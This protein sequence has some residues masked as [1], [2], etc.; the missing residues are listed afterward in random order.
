M[1]ILIKYFLTFL[2]KIYPNLFFLIFG[3]NYKKNKI[4][5]SFTKN[6]LTY[7]GIAYVDINEILFEKKFN[8]EEV[9]FKNYRIEESPHFNLI[10][11]Y[12]IYNKSH[13]NKLEH[14][15]YFKLFYHRKIILFKNNIHND[16]NFNKYFNRKYNN[17]KKLFNRICKSDYNK[18]SRFVYLIMV[19]KN[20]NY[21]N[22]LSGH[23][24][25][26]IL[27]YLKYSKIKVVVFE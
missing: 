14:S 12:F 9:F 8:N 21:Y 24:R 17:F 7:C 26:A 10:K 25:I 19:K 2:L 15:A 16:T 6:Q 1:K 23:H 11:D 20:K 3:V 27:K 22:I 18:E 4:I 5:N 13:H